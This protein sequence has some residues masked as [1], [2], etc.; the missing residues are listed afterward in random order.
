MLKLIRKIKRELY[1]RKIFRKNKN[2]LPTKSLSNTPKVEYHI[3]ADAIIWD[4]EGI[5]NCEFEFENILRSVVHYRTNLIEF[6]NFE[7]KN[8]DKRVYQLA[9]K[10][11]PEWVGFKKERCSFNFELSQRIKRLREV[12][13]WK[14][15]KLLD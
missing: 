14:I 9:K 13:N 12:S 2:I 5:N 1:V 4:D 3:L 8:S 7:S 15:D 10:Y 11:F 6:E